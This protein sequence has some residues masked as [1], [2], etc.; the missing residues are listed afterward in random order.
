[1]RRHNT[2][3]GSAFHFSFNKDLLKTEHENTI[4]RMPKA[5]LP[6]VA[7]GKGVSGAM[8]TATVAH[9][10]AGVSRRAVEARAQPKVNT[11]CSASVYLVRP[12]TPF[13]AAE[14]IQAQ[15]PG[16]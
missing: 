10:H 5:V 15:I 2:N 8:S 6:V 12:S 7:R 1:M 4:D 11:F 3:R 16:P 14:T 9:P 13:T